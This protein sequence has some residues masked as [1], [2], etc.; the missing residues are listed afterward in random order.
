MGRDF[1]PSRAFP[2]GADD[3]SPSFGRLLPAESRLEWP[4]DAGL[5]GSSESERP[6]PVRLPS[7]VL[8]GAIITRVCH[9]TWR[10]KGL[11]VTDHIKP[12]PGPH[13]HVYIDSTVSVFDLGYDGSNDLCQEQTRQI[14]AFWHH[15]LVFVHGTSPTTQVVSQL[16]TLEY[17]LDGCP[18]GIPSTG[19][20]C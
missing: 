9:T 1:D 3:S 18:L 10:D 2:A 6:R 11:D 16:L 15:L 4:Y 13:T 20:S 8:L 19:S 14:L 17:F 5:G 12:C 7:A